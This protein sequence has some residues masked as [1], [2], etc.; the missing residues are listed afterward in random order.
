ML[1][2]KAMSFEIAKELF[3]PHPPHVKA[4][5]QERIVEVGGQQPRALF[6][7]IPTQQE[8]GWMGMTGVQAYMG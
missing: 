2:V 5:D 1:D 7:P 4:I 6:T 3:D 8:V